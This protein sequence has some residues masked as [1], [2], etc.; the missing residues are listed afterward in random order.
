MA[1]RCPSVQCVG[2]PVHAE[3]LGPLFII[4]GV[5][6]DLLP[7]EMVLSGLAVVPEHPGVCGILDGLVLGGS[8]WPSLRC[9]ADAGCSRWSHIA[10]PVHG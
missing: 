1:S 5:Q 7:P 6:D 3:G 9:L 10:W 4:P 8:E 2:D